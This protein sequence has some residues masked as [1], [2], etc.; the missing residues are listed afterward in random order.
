MLYVEIR[1]A[2]DLYKAI[3]GSFSKGACK[4]L[5]DY[6]SDDE[7]WRIDKTELSKQYV[8]YRDVEKYFNDEQ[9]RRPDPIKSLDFGYIKYKN[10]SEKFIFDYMRDNGYNIIGGDHQLFVVDMYA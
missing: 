3:G 2:E 6:F 1:D 8:E 10:N 5:F 4:I 7:D 9:I